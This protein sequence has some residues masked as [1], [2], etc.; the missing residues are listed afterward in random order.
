MCQIGKLSYYFKGVFSGGSITPHELECINGTDRKI[1]KLHPQLLKDVPAPLKALPYKYGGL[2]ITTLH[3]LASITYIKSQLQ[4]GQTPAGYENLEITQEEAKASYKVRERYYAAKLMGEPTLR[5]RIYKT[6]HLSI[7]TIPL[8]KPPTSA[9]QFL[10]DRE[11]TSLIDQICE[12]DHTCV[13]WK[14]Y[15]TCPIHKDVQCTLDHILRCRPTS[16]LQMIRCHNHICLYLS[17]QLRRNPDIKNV[18]MESYS[19]KQADRRSKGEPNKRADIIFEHK[20]AQNSIDV[21]VTS[22]KKSKEKRT[23]P[24]TR[25]YNDKTRKYGREPNVH[26]IVFGTNGDIHTES[27]KYLCPWG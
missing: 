4:D 12:L 26:P 25:Q 27:W 1:E 17:R 22:G 21:A 2:N 6:E 5:N 10:S 9:K 14:N 7:I 19:D 23:D 8:Q 15:N 11:F 16:T 13:R 18:K 24:L 20:G 3:D